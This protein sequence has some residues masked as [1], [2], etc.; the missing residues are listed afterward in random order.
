[1]GLFDSRADNTASSGQTLVEFA[2]IVPLLMTLIMG[3]LELSVA[4]AANIGVNRAAQSAAHMAAQAGNVAGADCLILDEVEKAVIV[5]NDRARIESVRIELTD[6]GG[7]TVHA[8]NEWQ[9]SGSTRCSVADGLE[10]VVP[11]TRTIHYYPDDQRCTV[12]AGC[13]TMTPNRGTV[14]NI[15]VVVRY[16]HRWVTPIAQAIPMPGG[17]GTGWVIQ[18]RNVFRMEPHR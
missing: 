3:G 2:L 5:P 16:R 4:F 15:G 6:L 8:Y 12:L 10:I 1:M 11:Y 17:D 18:Q 14:D 13:P 9:R 7:D